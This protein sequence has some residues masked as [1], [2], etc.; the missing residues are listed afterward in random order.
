MNTIQD[1][2]Q[3]ESLTIVGNGGIGMTYKSQYVFVWHNGTI[4]AKKESTRHKKLY[5]LL[6]REERGRKGILLFRGAQPKLQ[7]E[8]CVF[9]AMIG[10]FKFNFQNNIT[11]EELKEIIATNMNP[12]FD[13]YERIMY[14]TSQ[15]YERLYTKEE[16]EALKVAEHRI[17]ESEI[18]LKSVWS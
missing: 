4:P 5:S 16:L 18:P 8:S 11:K 9:G 15:A 17:M 1:L 2:K 7:T 14:G 13:E 10:D 6:P 3:G 12:E